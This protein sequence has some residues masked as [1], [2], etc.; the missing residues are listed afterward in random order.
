MADFNR[1]NRSGGNR[2]YGKP[3]FNND[4]NDRPEMHQ[5]TC[6]SCGKPCEVPFRPNGSRPVLCRDCFQKE[7]GSDSRGSENRSDSRS[8]DR[9]REDRQM[10]D[11]VCSNCGDKCQI[12]FRPSQGRDVFCSRC[13]DMQSGSESHRPERRSFDRPTQN[14]D[15][16]RGRTNDAPNYKA[17]FEALNAKMDKILSLLNPAP[18][19]V[20]P[21]ESTISEEA[22]EEIVEEIEEEKKETGEKKPRKAKAAAKKSAPKTK[23]VASSKKK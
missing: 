22:I 12:P 16:N 10:F 9:P 3:R 19:T 20:E 7:K 14:R 13:F 1:D 23:K 11:A 15:D 6:A 5:A 21:L 8:F 18:A 17:Q 2:S 4:R